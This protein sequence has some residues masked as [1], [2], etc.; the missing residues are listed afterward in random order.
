MATFNL[1]QDL[2]SIDLRCE[3]EAYSDRVRSDYQ[4]SHLSHPLK[5]PVPFGFN[6]SLPYWSRYLSLDPLHPYPAELA[7]TSSSHPQRTRQHS[8]DRRGWNHNFPAHLAKDEGSTPWG[9]TVVLPEHTFP[10]VSCTEER[11]VS[12][13]DSSSGGST[14]SP[15][16]SERRLELEPGSTPSPRSYE[17]MYGEL[18][19]PQEQS[20][21]YDCYSAVLDG[22]SDDHLG[23]GIGVTLQDVQQYPDPYQGD[24]FENSA[25]SKALCS[26]PLDRPSCLDA[27]L[28]EDDPYCCPS[29]ATVKSSEHSISAAH[30]DD[31][32]DLKAEELSDVED[33]SDADYFPVSR[34]VPFKSR[35]RQS[36]R[37]SKSQTKQYT[38]SR[39]K[40][41]QRS[42]I[43]KAIKRSEDR[44]SFTGD[45]MQPTDRH[46]PIIGCPH[47]S[48]RP[49]T[50]SALSKHIATVHTRPFT[51]TFR[52][53]G[54]PATFG[55]KNE[56]KRHASSQHL[57]LGIW[58]CDIGTC[59]VQQPPLR[60]HD[61]NSADD[62]ELVYNDFNR[63]D[64]FTQHLKRMHSPRGSS[65]QVEHDAFA[66]SMEKASV[67]CLQNIRDPPLRSVCGY[68]AG[69]GTG[70]F[71]GEGSWEARMEHVGRHLESGDGDNQ[72]WDEDIGLRD[73]MAKEGLIEKASEGGGWRL[74][75]LQVDEGK[76]K[77][78]KKG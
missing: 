10:S 25:D 58:R 4:S 54:C 40:T 23:A 62:E 57:R 67:R 18:E 29:N 38:K 46:G 52:I 21:A 13:L 7:L 6:A 66:A 27:P 60:R 47:C 32:L 74:V 49:Q 71:E 68:C 55:S 36:C 61:H 70:L 35:P 48:C 43:V 50:K 53:Y 30:Q 34:N 9:V 2:P 8:S 31:S 75:G 41:D 1:F 59:R 64:L 44:R 26:F 78:T 5:A 17:D 77:R 22:S 24:Q 73:W 11:P 39:C 20:F 72:A 69:Q 3:S 16:P 63:K 56:W 65:S 42:K 12:E 76:N 14:W 37:V 51:C 28:K 15:G 45:L 19:T 33:D